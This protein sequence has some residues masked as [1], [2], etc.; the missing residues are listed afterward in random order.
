MPYTFT[1]LWFRFLHV[2][3]CPL[4]ETYYVFGYIIF[5]KFIVLMNSCFGASWFQGPVIKNQQ[6]QPTTLRLK[7][8][9][10]NGLNDSTFH[11]QCWNWKSDRVHGIWRAKAREKLQPKLWNPKREY[12]WQPVAWKTKWQKEQLQLYC[13]WSATGKCWQALSRS[14]QTVA[15]EVVQTSK[16]QQ[17]ERM[18]VQFCWMQC[19]LWYPYFGVWPCESKKNNV[20]KR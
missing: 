11:P 10:L 15:L 5:N 12:S 2:Y 14:L 8:C 20:Q 9:K 6:L 7:R 4:S 17:S 13:Q 19:F 3:M 18:E 16:V 1:L